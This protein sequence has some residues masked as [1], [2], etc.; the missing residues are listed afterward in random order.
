MNNS[1]IKIDKQ[2]AIES[3][4]NIYLPFNKGIN[5]IIEEY[6]INSET[7]KYSKEIKRKQR[8]QDY[9]WNFAIKIK[10]AKQNRVIKEWK[11]QVE[12]SKIQVEKKK[13]DL[14][15]ILVEEIY[16]KLLNIFSDEKSKNIG[17]VYY[18]IFNS[19]KI[20]TTDIYNIYETRFNIM[21]KSNEKDNKLENINYDMYQILNELC[22]N[23]FDMNINFVEYYSQG[24]K[25]YFSVWFI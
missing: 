14:S 17:E 21:L 20:E 5:R 9:V 19:I 15:N 3:L 2:I 8:I 13:V 7:M 6:V 22:L 25:Y 12:E 4:L 1:P 23:S 18:R 10:N 16:Q 11:I 24:D